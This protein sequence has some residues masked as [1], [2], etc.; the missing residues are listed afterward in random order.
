MAA[1]LFSTEYF[2][3]TDQQRM[4]LIKQGNACLQVI[5]KQGLDAFVSLILRHKAVAS[6]DP[7]RVSIHHKY[8]FIT[9]IQQNTVGRFFS[10]A[11]DAQQLFPQ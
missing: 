6:H 3:R 9:R 5:H 8:W 2:S 11:V 7:A 4:K 1:P 10:D